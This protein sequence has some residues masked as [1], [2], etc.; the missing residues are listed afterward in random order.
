MAC[1]AAAELAQRRVLAWGQAPLEHE[2]H[3]E[4]RAGHCCLCKTHAA[5]CPAIISLGLKSMKRIKRGEKPP[6]T[7]E[8]D[9]ESSHGVTKSV[10]AP[11]R[12]C[13]NVLLRRQPLLR[14]S[15][16]GSGLAKGTCS[17]WG[18]F[19]LLPKLLARSAR[20]RRWWGFVEG[21]LSAL[22]CPTR[23]LA[24]RARTPAL[25]EA[26]AGVSSGTLSCTNQH[27]P[28]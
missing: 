16:G 4:V 26:W 22:L 14:P 21:F 10:V 2:N 12:S 23:G 8:G 9:A 15:E 3:T 5:S 7:G 1:T 27:V 18:T 6:T 11:V 13:G 17:W 24:V 19:A 20:A 28:V 25:P